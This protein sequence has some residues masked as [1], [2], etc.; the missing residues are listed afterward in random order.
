MTVI[1]AT[2][3]VATGRVWMAADS[4][5]T[6]AEFAAK[7]QNEMVNPKIIPV[8]DDVL[9]GLAG[10]HIYHSIVRYHKPPAPKPG[11]CTV[12]WLQ[13]K[14]LPWLDKQIRKLNPNK[15]SAVML[16]ARAGDLYQVEMDNVDAVPQSV[17]AIGSGGSY[18]LGALH[19]LANV[20]VLSPQD[21]VLAAVRA[22]CEHDPY[23]GGRID[24]MHTGPATLTP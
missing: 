8:G 17:S 13:L 12:V 7:T 21:R 24:V 23:C 6:D 3:D 1:V 18:A 10:E 19:A 2:R 20:S 22:A 4:M 9:V 5:S 14:F 11:E 15:T 16:V